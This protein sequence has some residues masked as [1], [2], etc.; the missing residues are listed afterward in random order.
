VH[1]EILTLQELDLVIRTGLLIETVGTVDKNVTLVRT[2][3]A[4]ES[5]NNKGADCERELLQL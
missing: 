3:N 2:I 5:R 4:S 1:S